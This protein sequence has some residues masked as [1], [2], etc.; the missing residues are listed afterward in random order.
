MLVSESLSRLRLLLRDTDSHV[1]S[2]DVLVR[3]WD[4]CQQEFAVKSQLLE[5]VV[6]LP[7]PAT[8]L[9]T[10]TQPWEADYGG[11]PCA[12]LYNYMSPYSFTQPW[13][14]G[15][16]TGTDADP[17]GGYTVTQMWE[18]V[19]VESQNRIF[20]YFPDDCLEV[21]YL[22]YDNRPVEWAFREEIDASNTAFKTRSSTRP[23]FYAEDSASGIFYAY[24]RLTA[25]YGVT[26]LSSEYGEV[27]YDP[28]TTNASLNPDTDYGVIVYGTNL[29]IDSDYGVVIRAQ[30]DNDALQMIYTYS[31]IQLTSPSQTIEWPRWCVKYVEFALLAKLFKAETDLFNQ[32]LSD[33]YN[34]R[35]NYG[36]HM[37]ELFKSN[38]HS[39]RSYQM[40]SLQNGRNSQRRKLADLPSNYPSYWR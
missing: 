21:S 1:F 30:V 31:P 22:A 39:M 11:Q 17:T 28:D 38:Q 25:T 2:D 16:I 40:Q 29:E 15:L 4:E 5:R 6:N 34:A 20:H 36:L 7:V 3:L 10:Y 27:V 12:L 14:V 24:P 9:M 37:C 18:A 23:L 8:A 19:Q 33:F 26:E 13:E 32:A 35:Y